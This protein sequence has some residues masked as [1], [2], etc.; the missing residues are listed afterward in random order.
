[1]LVSETP[2]DTRSLPHWKPIR[3]VAQ[4]RE[5]IVTTGDA[6][7]LDGILAWCA[8][9]AH[10]ERDSLPPM[11]ST[12]CLDFAL[13]LATWRFGAD[14]GWCASAAQW[15]VDTVR[16]T[17]HVRRKP[18]EREYIQRTAAKTYDYGVGPAKAVNKPIPMA[19]A[20]TLH[21]YAL[22]D[23][24]RVR[25]L[26]GHMTHIGKLMAHGH[27][28]VMRWVVDTVDADWSIERDGALMRRMP[29]GWAGRPMTHRGA[30]RAPYHHRTRVRDAVGPDASA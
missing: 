20:R 8:Y 18:P 14:W 1:M 4:M 3:V 10:P 7:H 16:S 12:A 19:F 30:L 26:L 2:P 24:D 11:T 21:W 29:A 9:A 17:E 5:P 13:P 6:I 15:P 22:G 27:G 23:P 28:A 25:E